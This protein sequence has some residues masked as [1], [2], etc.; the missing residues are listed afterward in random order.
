M[1]YWSASPGRSR[2]SAVL[3]SFVCIGAQKAA[4]TWLYAQLKGH[5]QVFLPATKELNFFYRDLPASWYAQQFADAAGT[6]AA[7]DISPNYMVLP[8]VAERMHAVLPEARLICLLR[9][10][11]AR[12][13]SQYQMAVDLGNIPA[14]TPFLEAF[15]GNLQYLQERGQYVELLE[16]FTRHYPLGSKLQVF[17]YDDLLEDPARFLGAIHAWIGVAPMEAGADLRERVDGAGREF[18]LDTVA[19]RE[20]RE[21][22]RPHVEAL[23]R[24]LGRD[25]PGWR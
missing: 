22:Y 15:R 2:S 7:G 18:K 3:P 5:P 19:E 23:E 24:Y 16:R 25:L 17:L 10:P 21:F 14:G 12:A 13:R 11:V 9:E 4:T 8:G 6:Q 20:V 1:R